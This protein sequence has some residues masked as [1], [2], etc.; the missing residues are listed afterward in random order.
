M[1]N[2]QAGKITLEAGE[3]KQLDVLTKESSIVVKTPE[4]YT[5]VD[6][7]LTEIV[8]FKKNFVARCKPI[9]DKAN[10]LHKM[11]TGERARIVEPLE[12]AERLRKDALNVFREAERKRQEEAQR[13]LDEEAKKKADKEK[14]K[15]L[16]KAEK[17]KDPEKA[18]ELK[19]QAAEVVPVAAT[20]QSSVPQGNTTFR[21]DWYAEIV[22]KKLIP[23]EYMLP[24]MALLDKLAVSFK[25]QNA[26]AGV[27]YKHRSIPVAKKATV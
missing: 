3:K 25:G 5:R 6:Q 15:L 14:E 21:D 18:A 20:V 27:V 7:E 26:P 22:D 23:L 11:L 9:I 16:A 17:T 13:K 8:T 10:E 4:D 2:T 12:K 1:E 19:Q 24:D